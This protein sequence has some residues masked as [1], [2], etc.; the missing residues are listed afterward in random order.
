MWNNK[1]STG[2]N[3]KANTARGILCMIV[4]V[5]AISIVAIAVFME[6]IP[7]KLSGTSDLSAKNSKIFSETA[8]EEFLSDCSE[9]AS[10]YWLDK[11]G[12]SLN[13]DDMTAAQLDGAGQYGWNSIAVSTGTSRDGGGD[14]FILLE[15][16]GGFSDTL[17]DTDIIM[18]DN[19]QSTAILR[20]ATEYMDGALEKCKSGKTVEILSNTSAN[21]GRVMAGGSEYLLPVNFSV[22][23]RETFQP[24]DADGDACCFFTTPYDGTSIADFLKAEKESSNL[25]LDVKRIDLF[26]A[27]ESNHVIDDWESVYESVCSLMSDT[28]D[29]YA[30]IAVFGKLI[31]NGVWE[32]NGQYYEVL[33]SNKGVD[34]FA[35]AIGDYTY[36]Y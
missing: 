28:F 35:E 31:K 26:A 7:L 33:K 8:S 9:K 2:Q 4:A 16:P 13:A 24:D 23:F 11:Y 20:D 10:A 19:R 6:I 34:N 18:G 17:S 27:D 25:S 21:S 22:C 32:G 29:E 5:A 12:E 36:R 1:N 30:G 15:F 3:N 14:C